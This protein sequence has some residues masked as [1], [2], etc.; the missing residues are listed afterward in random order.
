MTGTPAF[1]ARLHGLR[2]TGAQTTGETEA[3]GSTRQRYEV[4]QNAIRIIRDHPV[5]GVGLGAYGLANF[6]YN[7]ALGTLDTHNTY[8]HILAETGVLGL[9]LY[10]AI[11][12]SVIRSARDARRRAAQVFPAHAETLRWLQYAFVGHLIAGLFGSFSTFILPW[13]F[14]ALLWSASQTVRALCPP[15]ATA[16][17]PIRPVSSAANLDASRRWGI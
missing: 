2:T 3:Q 4:L 5:V 1:W 13:I 12:A 7:P 15:A 9:V 10:L 11:V 16:P 8:L 17:S 6:R 14:M